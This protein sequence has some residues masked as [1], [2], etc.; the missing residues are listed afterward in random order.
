MVA[1]LGILILQKVGGDGTDIN[2][3]I[4][5]VL[6]SKERIRILVQRLSRLAVFIVKNAHPEQNGG[7]KQDQDPWGYILRKIANIQKLCFAS[8]RHSEQKNMCSLEFDFRVG[9]IS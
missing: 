5:L 6:E 1:G 2:L 8:L 9:S 3:G 4:Q 7:L